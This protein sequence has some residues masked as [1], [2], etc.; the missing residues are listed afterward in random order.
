MSHSLGCHGEVGLVVSGM[1]CEPGLWVHRRR[2]LA[3][4]L[5]VDRFFH[6]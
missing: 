3:V 2:R 1:S 4:E 6:A 5:E